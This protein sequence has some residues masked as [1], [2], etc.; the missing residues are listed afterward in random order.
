MRICCHSEHGSHA[1]GTQSLLD[2]LRSV[3][4]AYLAGR[5]KKIDGLAVICSKSEAGA[6][7]CWSTS[8]VGGVMCS[9]IV[10]VWWVDGDSG[11]GY[12]Y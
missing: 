6:H 5:G 2:S 9:G 3:T 7:P 11:G 10:V 1:H 8:V 12:T 4:L